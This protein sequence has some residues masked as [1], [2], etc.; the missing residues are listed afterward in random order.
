MLFLKQSTSRMVPIGP[1]VDATDGATLETAIT[2]STGEAILYKNGAASGVNVG[3]NTWSA[4]VAGGVYMLTLTASDTDTLGTLTIVAYDAAMRP[5]RLDAMVLPAN[6]WDSLFGADKLDVNINQIGEN[7]I[8][9]FLSSTNALNSD[10]TK[11]NTS[12]PAAAGLADA[13]KTIVL[14]TVQSGSTTTVVKTNL[15]EATNDHYNG[16]LMIFVTGPLAGQAANISD[17]SGASHDVT[18][19]AL[20]EAPSNGDTFVIV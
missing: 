3:T 5:V 4:H 13:S 16:R 19:S 6:V 7:A 10:V 12:A 8:A 2:W 1:C 18:V 14:G 11:I 17:Y 9:N 20:T 15:T